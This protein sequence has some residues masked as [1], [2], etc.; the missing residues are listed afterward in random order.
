MR[1]KN[2]DLF[3]GFDFQKGGQYFSVT[4]M[5]INYSGLGIESVGDNALGNPKRDPLTGTGIVDGIAVPAAT[6]GNNSGGILVEGVDAT[7]G[8]PAAYYVDPVQY[9][10]RLFGLSEFYL[11][12]A[13]YI[14]LRTL[15]L[16]YNLPK[17][18]LDQTPFSKANIAFY[19]NNL[20]LIDSDLNFVDPSEL[21]NIGWSTSA[22]NY[23][24]IEGGQLPPA[25]TL[26]LNVSLTF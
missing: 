5:F 11:H 3:L 18:F 8:N 19:A 15:R 1:Y 20:W 4:D 10:G 22:N 21:E 14:K 23:N 12:D 6:A 17:K 2:F 9:Y 13:S 25:R 24:F 7:S 16:G 26:G